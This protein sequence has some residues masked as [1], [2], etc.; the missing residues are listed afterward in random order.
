MKCPKCSYLGFET[1]DRCKNCGYDFSLLPDSA[2]PARQAAPSDV[3]FAASQTL[4]EAVDLPLRDSAIDPLGSLSFDAALAGA[5]LAASGHG[6]PAR[7]QRVEARSGAPP[8]PLFQRGADQDDEPLIKLP[9]SPRPPLAVRRTPDKPRPRSTPRPARRIAEA[10]SL[11]RP[12]PLEPALFRDEPPPRT[13]A[14]V[15]PV[16]RAAATPPTVETSG[17]A[18][19]FVAAAIDHGMLLAVDAIVVYFTLKMAGLDPNQWRLLPPVPLLAFLGMVKA[20]Y[21]CAFTLVGGQTIGK[22][23]VRIRVVGDDGDD[24]DPARAIRRT[25]AGACS[26]L[27][28]G[29]GFLPVLLADDRRGIH[30]RVAR[31]RVIALPSGRHTV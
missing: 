22:M 21:F 28:A 3:A 12:E 23:A 17:A 13:T 2:A 19:R 25:L 26:L 10:P 1:G 18:R 9:V 16:S 6:E 8:L 24:L 7:D 30:D 27:A 29:L 15:R 11:T 4:A 20:A 31:T 5:G 14:D